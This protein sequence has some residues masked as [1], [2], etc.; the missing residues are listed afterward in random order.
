M[1]A[2]KQEK[3]NCFRCIYFVTTWEP[4]HPRACRLYGFKTAGI[5]SVTVYNSTGEQCMGFREKK[6]R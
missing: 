3:I 4:R 2:G 6:K 5:P 1:K